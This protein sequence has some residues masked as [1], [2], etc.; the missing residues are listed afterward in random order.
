VFDPSFR[1]NGCHGRAAARDVPAFRID[2]H[3]VNH[4]RDAVLTDIVEESVISR[5]RL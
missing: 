3:G 1:T 2:R 5:G 4:R